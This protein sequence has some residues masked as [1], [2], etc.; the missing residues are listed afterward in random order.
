MR[1]PLPM[2]PEGWR[3]RAFGWVMERLN[4]SAYATA[5]DVL[6]PRQGE[7]VLEI[8]FGT[9]RFAE[10]LL[11]RAPVSVCGVDPAAT[12]VDVANRRGGIRAAPG[13]ADLRVGDAAALPWRAASFDAAVAIHCFQFW[14]DPARALGEIARVLRPHGRLVLVLR[15][16]GGRAPEWLPNPLSRGADEV[17]A[18]RHALQ[19]CGFGV[20][21]QAAAGSSTVLC[22]EADA[23]RPPAARLRAVSA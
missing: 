6:A 7:R 17:A 5:L 1:T 14:P 12:M 11:R 18:A 22:A 13:R 8:G 20:Y 10:L 15:D 21:A 9:G 3:G 4:A 19:R 16:H 23:P 2:R